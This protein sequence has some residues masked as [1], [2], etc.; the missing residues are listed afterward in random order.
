MPVGSPRS[1]SS[2][3]VDYSVFTSGLKP[4]TALPMQHSV[5]SPTPISVL[6]LHGTEHSLQ[7]FAQGIVL[8]YTQ[9]AVINLLQA[10]AQAACWCHIVEP[11]VCVSYMHSRTHKQLALLCATNRL[12]E[13]WPARG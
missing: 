9:F 11:A 5:R 8:A 3:F 4:G 1:N 12:P 10:K 2:G 7:A 6:A 13:P